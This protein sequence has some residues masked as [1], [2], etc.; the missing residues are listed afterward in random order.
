M[1]QFGPLT[2]S[3]GIVKAASFDH[4]GVAEGVATGLLMPHFGETRTR[5]DGN[6]DEMNGIPG[7]VKPA[8]NERGGL[9]GCF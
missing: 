1:A 8:R 7:G 9:R 3:C 6:G 2:K 4:D 5:R